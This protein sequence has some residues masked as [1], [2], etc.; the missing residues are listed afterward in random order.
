MNA[1][2]QDAFLGRGTESPY[3]DILNHIGLFYDEN[4]PTKA[5]DDFIQLM[6]PDTRVSRLEKEWELLGER[7]KRKYGKG[8]KATGNDRIQRDQKWNELR[9]AR[10]TQRRNVDGIFRRQ[11]FKRMNNEEIERQMSGNRDPQQPLQKII[12]SSPERAILAEIASDL[13]IELPEEDLRQRKVKFIDTMAEYAWKIEPQEESKP[14]KNGTR[15]ATTR[16]GSQDNVQKTVSEVS[17]P[18][19][20]IAPK[21]RYT[22]MIQVPVSPTMPPPEIDLDPPPPYAPV[23]PQFSIRT[24]PRK[25]PSRQT[26]Q[27]MFCHR[28]FTRKATMWNC[29]E[30]HLKLRKTGTVTCPD[31]VCKSK[32]IIL[33]NENRFKNHA[34][35]I[36]GWELRP[37]RIMIVRVKDTIVCA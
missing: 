7:L 6:G 21:P 29:A 24:R 9:T 28:N 3:L 35:K 12:F 18:G 10:Q 22:S 25:H 36:H 20:A 33:E 23:D 5:C 8:S 27:C 4:A 11:Y 32:G 14:S 2:V 34:A 16:A 31:T 17:A 37:Q 19:R 13:V 15:T 30:R 26:H 1:V